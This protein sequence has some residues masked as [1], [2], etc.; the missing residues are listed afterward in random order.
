MTP[1]SGTLS[2][3]AR[4]REIA[5]AFR[6]KPPPHLLSRTKPLSKETADGVEALLRKWYERPD[7]YW[8]TSD[9]QVDLKGHTG[10]RLADQRATVVPWLDSIRPLEG[11]RILEIGCGTGSSTLALAEQG[12]DVTALDFHDGA[13]RIARGLFELHGVHAEFICANASDAHE[14]LDIDSYDL[15]VFLAVLEHMTPIECLC[16][17]NAYWEKMKPGAHLAVMDTP[18]RLWIYD[19]HTA[20]LPFFHWL[21]S[22]IAIRYS[23]LCPV[24]RIA[25][26][27]EDTSPDGMLRLQRWGRGISFHEFELAIGPV[28]ELPIVSSFGAWRRRRDFAQAAKWIVRDRPYHQHLRRAAPH[29]PQPWLEPYMDLVIR[30]VEMKSVPRVRYQKLLDQMNPDQK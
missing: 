10:D 11:L 27:H 21:P 12:A 24:P 22:E 2:K 28:G 18:N 8:E 20:Y 29:V 1:T 15:I 30:R 23:A 4:I 3:N 7:G 5:R 14:A 25:D 26:L 17:L 9:G 19:S 6:P 16:S 13:V